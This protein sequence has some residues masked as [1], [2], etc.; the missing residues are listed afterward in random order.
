MHPTATPCSQPATPHLAGALFF[1]DAPPPVVT[2]EGKPRSKRDLLI[3]QHLQL[4]NAA[5]CAFYRAH[6][7]AQPAECPTERATPAGIAQ[8]LRPTLDPNPDPDLAPFQP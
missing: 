4:L 5:F 7:G 2:A 1:F 6:C 3:T 8:A